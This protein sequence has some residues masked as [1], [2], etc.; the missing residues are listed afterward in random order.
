MINA[1]D[2]GTFISNLRK[3]SGLTQEE[4]ASQFNVSHQ[5]VSKWENGTTIPDIE[6]LVDI[7][8]TYN[9]S[10]DHIIRGKTI[11]KVSLV[12]EFGLG[13]IPYIHA[14]EENSLLYKAIEI[15]SKIED[16]KRCDIPKIRF[17]DNHQ[18]KDMEYRI[19]VDGE[20][21]VDN[22]LESIPEYDRI[23]SMLNFLELVLKST[24]F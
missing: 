8:D 9:V 1:K 24:Y 15:R 18:L 4:F 5:A 13:M 23:N 2:S 16:I 17:M 12:F 7:A 3:T 11:N 20:I 22:F 21:V 19:L 6:T 10:V 14:P